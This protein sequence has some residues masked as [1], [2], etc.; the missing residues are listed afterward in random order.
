MLGPGVKSALTGL[1]LNITLSFALIY[2]FG[3][4]GA[5]VGV[6]ITI[7]A[8]TVL[9]LYWFHRSTGYPLGEILA[10]AYLKPTVC[11][12]VIVVLLVE[13]APL[14]DFGWLGLCVHASSFGVLYVLVLLRTR[15][16]DLFDLAQV[17]GFLPVARIARRIMPGA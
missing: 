2:K 8:T 11:A 4:S 17:E 16:F 9:F 14:S 13:V 3:F 10:R 5:V 1:F 15:F 6:F 12:I 7:M